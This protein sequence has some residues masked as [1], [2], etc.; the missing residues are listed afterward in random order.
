M[1]KEK[2]E[3]ILCKRCGTEF[4]YTKEY[5]RLQKSHNGKYYLL[6]SC[7]DCHRRGSNAFHLKHRE[8]RILKMRT[9]LNENRDWI[10]EKRRLHYRETINEQLEKARGYYYKNKEERNKKNSEYQKNNKNVLSEKSRIRKANRR[11]IDIEYALLHRLRAN[12][13]RAISKEFKYGRTLQLLGCSIKNLKQYLESQF[14]PGM[15]W[16]NHTKGGWH[17]DHI[18]PCSHFDLTKEDQQK[19]CFH[20]SN[21]QPLWEIDNLK[22]GNRTKT[23]EAICIN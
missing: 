4:P 20:Y 21:L 1:K 3:T 5:F 13:S 2:P 11:K 9:Y 12:V 14:Q 17:I 7:L 22:K 10:N 18:I 6:H 23:M 19:K 15:T 16:N 8:E